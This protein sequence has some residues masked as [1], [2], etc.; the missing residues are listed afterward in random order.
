MADKRSFTLITGR[1]I[2][3]GMA[4]VSGKNNQNY[5][6]STAYVELNENIL[7]EYN[8]SEGKKILLYTDSG[9]VELS[10]KKGDLP[11]EIVFIPYGPQANK[12]IGT[13]TDGTGMPSSKGKKVMIKRK[14]GEDS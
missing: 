11:E 13:D 14:E 9:E 4:S 2:K 5:E 6:D 10:C 1:T 12:L 3:Q 7:E 8:L